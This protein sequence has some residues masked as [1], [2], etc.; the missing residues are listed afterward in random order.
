MKKFVFLLVIC[1]MLTGCGMRTLK[2][3]KK[4]DSEAGTL[5]YEIT[6]LFQKNKLISTTV[7][8]CLKLDKDYKDYSN[9]LI[10]RFKNVLKKY[11]DKKGMK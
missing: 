10:N 11:D 7:D 6:M 1:L 5:T 2:C 3:V 9:V 4:N 8:N